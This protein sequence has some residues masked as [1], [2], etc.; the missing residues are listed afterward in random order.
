MKKRLLL[1]P[2]LAGLVMG[3]C[4]FSSIFNKKDDPGTQD[5]PID[6]NTPAVKSVAIN[7]N[8]A[9]LSVGLTMQLSASVEV[10]NGASNSVTWSTSAESVATVSASGLVTGIAEGEVTITATSSF[11]A[12][13]SASV[14]IQVV[15]E[16]F[17][18]SFLEEGFTY[19]KEFPVEK[20]KEFL[21]EGEYEILG[22]DNLVGGCYYLHSQEEDSEEAFVIVVDG[23]HDED[24]AYAL[25]EEGFDR[26]YYSYKYS[27]FEAVDPT[28]KYTVDV[29]SGFDEETY[30]YVAPTFFEFYKSE[31]VWDSSELTSDAAWDFEK[32]INEDPDEIA[33]AKEYLELL[34]F[35]AL[36][37]DYEIDM[38]IDD[39]A[40]EEI[41][42]FLEFFGIDPDSL[43][44]EELE[45]YLEA[46]GYTGPEIYLTIYDYSLAEPFEGYDE[47]LLGAGYKAIVDEE[48]YEYYELANGLSAYFVSY[49]FEETGNTIYVQEGVAT[50]D[51]FPIDEVNSFIETVIGSEN[52]AI[53]Y[54]ETEGASFMAQIESSD[55]VIGVDYVYLEEAAAY[56]AKYEAAGF[57]VEYTPAS[58]E[59]YPSWTCTKGKLVIDFQLE[60]TYDETSE[61]YLDEG[62]LYIFVYGDETKHETQGIYLPET[63]SA[64]LS[65]G[66]FDLDL[67]VVKLDNPTLQVTSSNTDV[68]TV[69][70]LTVT[71]VGGGET[72]I[73]VTAVGT[74]FVASTVL[75]VN[76]KSHYDIAMEELNE[77]LASCGVEEEFILPL[78]T[79]TTIAAEED[80]YYDGYYECY[81]IFVNTSTTPDAY[82]SQL[83]AEGFEL[84]EDEYGSFATF[85][86]VL[87]D[88]FVSGEGILEID[89]YYE[90]ASVGGEGASFD[91]SVLDA[92]TGEANGFE[93]VTDKASGQS[94]PAYNENKAELRL[95]ANNTI[96]FT[97]EEPMTSIFFDANTCGESKATATFTSASTGT[98]TAVD[99]GFLWEGSA[100]EVTLTVSSSGQIHINAIEINGGG[101]GGGGQQTADSEEAFIQELVCL[102]FDQD[103]AELDVDYGYDDGYYTVFYGEDLT[104]SIDELYSVLSTIY[105]CE[106][107]D[108]DGYHGFYIDSLDGTCYADV[109]SYEYG[110]YVYIEIDIW[111]YED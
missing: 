32:I 87:I 22:L 12:T 4:D 37:E 58:D 96:T 45:M 31:D 44:E 90:P 70:G 38:V 42:M 62:P 81:T 25:L 50:L 76:A 41:L 92:V 69:S 52:S 109:Y 84:D 108:E 91:F 103:S 64:M 78:P 94:A 80:Y 17:D 83:E 40:K 18:P 1:L 2:L 67:E 54:E 43:T 21:G 100:T 63:M 93:F 99:G 8:Q 71:L 74:G 16:G 35:V 33:L 53:A 101:E 55:M 27:C 15:E 66:S 79:G 77:W 47:D 88:S 29:Y 111:A 104:D 73:T 23:V 105:D 13:K 95:Y 36:G 28:G 72:T 61:E 19:S 26:V 56:A 82:Y 102:I 85:G 6:E 86:D 3:G 107:Y 59:Y 75:S 46:F 97:S 65:D 14:T 106:A 30:E 57:E 110:G 48:G 34:P 5:T 98:V 10:V 49:G 24:Y 68:A 11:D 39:S 89:V 60:Q 51:A 9:K 7:G 20:I